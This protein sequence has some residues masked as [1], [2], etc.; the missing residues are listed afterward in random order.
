MMRWGSWWRLAVLTLGMIMT[1]TSP[2]PVAAQDSLDLDSLFQA[3]RR[4]LALTAGHA[5]GPGF[6]WIVEQSARAQFVMIGE[7][8]NLKDIPLFTADLFEALAERYGFSYLAL[9]NGPHAVEMFNEPGTRGDLDAAA[10]LANRYVN[11]LQFRTD[12]ELE[13]IAR[14]GAASRAS[15]DPVWGVDNA[16]GTLHLLESISAAASDAEARGVADALANR[17]REYEAARPDEQNP[18]FITQLLSEA[19]LLRLEDAYRSAGPE[20]YRLIGILR[21][22]W[23]TYAMRT[24]GPAIYQA[25]DRRE[26]LMRRQFEE[27]YREAV[28]GGDPLPRVVLKFG[29]W[30]AMS[31]MI[32][33][34]NVVPFGTFLRESARSRDMEMLSLW[35]GLVNEPG[36]V[37]TLMDFPDYSPLARAGTT[38]SWWVVDLREVRPYVAAGAVGEVNDELRKVIFGF[39][40]ALLIGSGDRA[41]G[42]RLSTR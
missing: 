19:D 11:A 10:D 42:D 6:D 23:E 12:Q 40:L 34:G 2:A 17:A 38:D 5:N 22:G 25:N 27:R 41:T 29:Q 14:T 18:R 7:S 26:R 20:A 35:T 16:W 8:H 13:L 30:H 31:G 4:R 3:H 32:N 9:E 1:V 37:W 28:A 21:M 39:D 15:Y 36:H 33:W 24:D